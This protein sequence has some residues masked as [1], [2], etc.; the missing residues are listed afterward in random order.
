MFVPL[1]VY[2]AL[3][4]A[5]SAF[6]IDPRTSFIDDKQL[7]LFLI[8][9][10]VYYLAR[11]PRASMVLTVVITVGAL[12]ALIGIIQYGVLQYDSL[13]RRPEGLLT[14]YM[15]YSGLLVLVMGAAA[16]RALFSADRIWPVI[17]M[18]AS[19][20]RSSS[21]SPWGL[22]RRLYGV[23]LLLAMRDSGS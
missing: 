12:S 2:A 6:A 19:W 22:G 17:V 16:A 15:T 18:P 8:V 9:P 14:H 7:I 11:G 4:L 1:V 10:A 20:R 3:P 5:S 21:R 13:G 23:A